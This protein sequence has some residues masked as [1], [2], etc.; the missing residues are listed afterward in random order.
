[1]M[2]IAQAAA[3]FISRQPGGSLRS[4]FAEKHLCAYE[5]SIAI[6]GTIRE[7]PW[8]HGV[9]GKA[10]NNLGGERNGA[11]KRRHA[12]VDTKQSSTNLC[13]LLAGVLRWRRGASCR[14]YRTFTHAPTDATCIMNIHGTDVNRHAT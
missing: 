4:T 11:T 10:A 6:S 7:D 1:M 12:A 13:T 14:R 3:A 9:A 5:A 2:H 8:R